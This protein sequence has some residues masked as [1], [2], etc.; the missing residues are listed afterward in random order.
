M[1][2]VST[3]TMVAVVFAALL[4]AVAVYAG[5][6]D[7]GGSKITDCS[8]MGCC[9]AFQRSGYN[10]VG[11]T[12]TTGC[13]TLGGS[14]SGGPVGQCPQG[15]HKN[16]TCTA[17]TCCCSYSTQGVDGTQCLP[18]VSCTYLKGTCA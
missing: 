12:T 6:C 10:M 1:V 11:C 9:C 7:V 4:A 3:S 5:S 16:Q 18:Q 17:G 14:C 15:E 13:A 8:A 2:K